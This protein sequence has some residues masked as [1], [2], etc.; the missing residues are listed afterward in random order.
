MNV[1]EKAEAGCFDFLR[2]GDYV[3]FVAEGFCICAAAA[4]RISVSRG[5]GDECLEP[6]VVE[7]VVCKNGENI[8]FRAVGVVNFC[9]VTFVFLKFGDVGAEDIVAVFIVNV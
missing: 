8:G 6:D 5:G 4:S 1:K 7:T 2:V 3:I 9:A